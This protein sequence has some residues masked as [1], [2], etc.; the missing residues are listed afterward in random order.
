[1]DVATLSVASLAHMLEVE[2]AVVADLL[3]ELGEDSVDLAAPLDFGVAQ[4]LALEL[5]VTLVATSPRAGE[6]GAPRRVE[7]PPV[8]AVMGHVDHGKTS[9]LDALRKTRVAAKEE[10]GITQ[11]IGAFSAAN[12][13]WLDT[14]G[15]ALFTAMRER[16][17]AATDVALLVVAADQGAQPQTVEAI[18]IAR[19]AGVPLV[20]ALN[21]MDKPGADAESA[22]VS[23]LEHGIVVEDLGGDVP[24]VEVSAKE[25]TNLDALC[26]LVLLQ[27]ELLELVTDPAAPIA[28]TVIESDVSPKAGVTATLLL[29][30]G[31]LRLGDVVV[32]GSAW[33]RVRRM[34]GDSGKQL[35][36]AAA[37]VP[38]LIT[39]LRSVPAAGDQV[40]V[41]ESEARARQLTEAREKRALAAEDDRKVAARRALIDAERG[42]VIANTEGSEDGPPVVV[43]FVI[44]AD[45]SGGLDAMVTALASLP[46]KRAYAQVVYAGVGAVTEADVQL[47]GTCGA[48]VIAYAVKAAARAQAEAHEAGVRLISSG[49]IYTLLD[50]AVAALVA[51]IPPRRVETHIG[52]G[53]V[54]DSFVITATPGLMARG[55][56]RKAAVGGIRVVSG[57]IRRGALAKV[58]RDGSE[59]FQGRVVS[60]R[61]YKDDVGVVN[62]G[63]ECGAIMHGAWAGWEPGDAVDCFSVDEVAASSLD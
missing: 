16:G 2:T 29:R 52:R 8:A 32:A 21:K 7:R 30:Q 53:Q 26:D 48:T 57:V 54:L 28:G 39:G 61:H 4:L 42:R 14:P 35:K 36:T 22:K 1:M 24:C 51:A 63:Q 31:T 25:G 59:V 34:T 12:I 15:H 43:P 20:V 41:V 23:L 17:V 9:I 13:T 5:G 50:E 33:G 58:V 45:S 18:R 37:S 47:A 6:A 10:G 56:P 27:A 38:V 46:A 44:K 55:L 49:V 11:R 3:E 19:D 60:L 40:A 62:E